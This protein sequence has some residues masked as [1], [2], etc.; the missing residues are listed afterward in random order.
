MAVAL[1]YDNEH[2]PRVVARGEGA[3]AERILELA[4]EH[5]VPVEEDPVLV[6]ALSGIALDEEIPEQLYE[7]VARIISFVLSL[8]DE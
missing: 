7:A 6:A 4:R 1:H 5:G 3:V 8:A 2:A